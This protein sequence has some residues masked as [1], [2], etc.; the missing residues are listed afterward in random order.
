MVLS[1]KVRMT[2][3]II[4]RQSEVLDA[5]RRGR[6]CK[7]LYCI[8]MPSCEENLLDIH[9]YREIYDRKEYDSPYQILGLAENRQGAVE[10][11]MEMARE[12]AAL[13]ETPG[14]YREN[15]LKIRDDA[16]I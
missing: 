11:I 10:L 3:N 15:F 14:E 16:L 4:Q 12:A 5:I 13:T 7:Y 1:S 2:E 9:P 8:T 6:E